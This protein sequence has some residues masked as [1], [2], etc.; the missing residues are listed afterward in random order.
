MGGGSSDKM[1]VYCFKLYEEME[2][3]E[4]DNGLHVGGGVER[5]GEARMASRFL[6]GETGQNVVPF[7]KVA[8]TRSLGRSPRMFG[9]VESET[10]VER[11]VR[12]PDMHA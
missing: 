5:G 10:R 12:A 2:I 9:H 4:L 6:T 7:G 1:K 11:S 8:K 3:I